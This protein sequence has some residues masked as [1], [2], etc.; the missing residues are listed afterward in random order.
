MLHARVNEKYHL[1]FLKNLQPLVANIKESMDK[2]QVICKTAYLPPGLLTFRYIS[3]NI[4]TYT[5]RGDNSLYI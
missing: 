3:N 5:E 1:S 2:D 4:N